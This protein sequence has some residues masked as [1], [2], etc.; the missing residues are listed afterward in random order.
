[1]TYNVRGEKTIS[2][3][4]E[5]SGWDKRQATVLL[6]INANGS[7]EL[8]PLIVFRGEPSNE[9]GSIFEKEKD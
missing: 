3:Q 6:I 2:T 7:Q 1:M 8:I 5:K 4:A 9:G